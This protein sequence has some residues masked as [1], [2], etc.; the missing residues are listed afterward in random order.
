[1]STSTSMMMPIIINFD[2]TILCF[3]LI[4]ICHYSHGVNACT[5]VRLTLE[6]L[7]SEVIGR[8]MELGGTTGFRPPFP[9]DPAEDIQPPWKIG[10]T[11]K[12]VY[13]VL[14]IGM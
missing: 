6:E 12:T 1:M 9:I 5:S 7:D 13:M 2:W 11:Q 14:Q 10:N 4:I 3:L 8:T